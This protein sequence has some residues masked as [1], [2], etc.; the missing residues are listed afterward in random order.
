MMKICRV[1][2]ILLLVIAVIHAQSTEEDTFQ[3][4]NE[5]EK[6]MI[7]DAYATAKEFSTKTANC[8]NNNQCDDYTLTWIGASHKKNKE[9]Y[10]YVRKLFGRMTDALDVIHSYCN[11]VSCD[12]NELGF[13]SGDIIYF[14]APFFNATEEVRI[15]TIISVSSI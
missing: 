10:D 1:L 8:L 5:S 15:R 13:P 14:C 2:S 6:Q 11:D 12:V 7:I 4:C 3:S 9:Q